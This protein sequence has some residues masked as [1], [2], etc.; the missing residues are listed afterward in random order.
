MRVAVVGSGGREDAM[1][2]ALA[3][4]GH[5][6]SIAPGNG[7][8]RPWNS[9]PP[10]CEAL[11]DYDLVVIGPEQPLADG[12]A[13]DLRAQGTTVFGAGKKAALLESS[14]AFARDFCRRNEIPSPQNETF[15]S[16]SLALRHID[17]TVGP[18]F[19]KASGLAGGKGALPAPDVPT[20]KGHLRHLMEGGLGHA[21]E[22]VVI[23][24]WE[25]G[26]E[27]SLHLVLGGEGEPGHFPF[28]RDHKRAYDDDRGPN[29][30]GMGAFAPLPPKESEQIGA[31]IKS[32]MSRIV[33]GIER[34]GID[35]RGVLFPGFILTPEGPKLLEFNVRF[36]DPE[37]EVL[38]PLLRGDPAE[39]MVAAATGSGLAQP[40]FSSLSALT[41]ILASNGYPEHPVSG[42]PLPPLPR[43]GEPDGKSALIFQA[44]TKRDG[45]DLL[46]SGG[47]ILAV[48]GLG[49]TLADA[50]SIAYNA[51]RPLA[52]S[53]TR[54]REDIG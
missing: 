21:G 9:I 19:I 49:K 7:G 3:R 50:K 42:I 14:K 35:F 39:W 38:F 52:V 2:W 43:P 16:L 36:G 45:E 41:V 23:E 13:D 44:G 26:P 12:L 11:V 8:S 4:H 20:A 54:F 32:I 10:T 37:T 53:G 15:D 25:E 34:E 31:E 46:S 30:G 18:W 29:T 5:Q 28:A 17:S 22:V 51:I 40:Q 47:R 1:G 48:T 27:I 33:A 6:V 24:S